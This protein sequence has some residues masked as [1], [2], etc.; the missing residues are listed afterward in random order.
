MTARLRAVLGAVA[1]AGGLLLVV[2]GSVYKGS[3]DLR[4]ERD[5]RLKGPD[6]VPARHGGGNFAMVLG[7]FVAL[8]GAA[9]L[10]I[11]FRDLARQIGEVRQRSEAQFRNELFTKPA[12]RTPDPG[13]R[14]PKPGV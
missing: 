10:A 2:G 5:L 14:G 4:Y 7:L 11:G 6:A 9:V 12:P 13:P 8:G 1:L 3:E